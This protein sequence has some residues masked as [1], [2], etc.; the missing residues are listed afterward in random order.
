MTISQDSAAAI[1]TS[2]VWALETG[3][4]C[5]GGHVYGTYA[6]RELAADDFIT[7]VAELLERSGER[8]LSA[9]EVRADGS[10]YAEVRCDYV[11]LSPVALVTAAAERSPAL[12]ALAAM[13]AGHLAGAPLAIETGAYGGNDDWDSEY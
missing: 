3:E 7:K 9:L 2:Q 13:V 6:S 4:V 12:A 10:V 5:E 11:E 1:T 8:E